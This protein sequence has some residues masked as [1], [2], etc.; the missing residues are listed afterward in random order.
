MANLGLDLADVWNSI[1]KLPQTQ[2]DI[3]QLAKTTQNI[4]SPEVQKKLSD[5]EYQVGNFGKTIVVL[6]AVVAGA[7]VGMLI[8]AIRRGK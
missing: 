3:N 2:K 8:L 4:Q 1:T 6:Q 5:L 7:A